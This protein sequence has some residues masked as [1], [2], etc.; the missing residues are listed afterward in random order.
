MKHAMVLLVWL[1]VSLAAAANTLRPGDVLKISVF[2]LPE[3]DTVVRIE[4]NESFRFPQCGEIKTAGLSTSQVAKE[5]TARLEKN[6]IA[7]PYVDVFVQTWEPRKVYVIGEV[8]NGGMS[9][10][11]SP[12]GTT[13]A[14]QAISAA[15]G[16]SESADLQK[17]VLLRRNQ[18]KVTRLPID[19]SVLTTGA[20]VNSSEVV[21]DPEDTII[22]P[23]SLPVSVSGLVKAT[24]MFFVNTSQLPTVSEMISR[25]GGLT[26]A[27]DADRVLLIRLE[28]DKKRSVH[29]VSLTQVMK[30]QFQENLVVQ[31]GDSLIVNAANQ[32]YVMGEVKTPGALTVRPGIII[33]ASRAIALAGGFTTIAKKSDVI[34]IRGNEIQ[35]LNLSKAYDSVKNLGLDVE[36][37]SGDVLYVK[38]SL[39]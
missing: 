2:R 7:N 3:F 4:Q 26:D 12:S 27:A 17:V 21:L 5:L 13:T 39:F 9:L 10:D 1:T 6:N 11:L 29:P 18:G 24:G 33:S 25:A 35:K 30:G 8:K 31:P 19:V 32:I 37:K 23:K 20:T 16:F 22:V 36:L 14:M 15:G 28:A 38:E 34:L